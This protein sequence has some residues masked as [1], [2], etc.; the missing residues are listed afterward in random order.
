MKQT[1]QVTAEASRILSLAPAQR[2]QAIIDSPFT[3]EILE[4]LPTQDAYLIIKESF[5]SDSSILLQYSPPERIGDFIDLD[6]WEGDTL[7][8][9]NLCA[10]IAELAQA[11]TETLLD[12]LENLDPSLVILLFQPHLQVVITQPTDDNIPELI[13]NGYE[14]FDN[15]YFFTFDELSEQTQIL[16]TLLDTLFLHN[17]DLYYRVLEGVRWEL[18]SEM[19]E[20]AYQ[21]RA[22]RLMELGFPPP[23]EAKSIYRH[24]LPARIIARGLRSDQIPRMEDNDY[25]LPSLYREAITQG[26]LVAATD[27]DD[28]TRER[29]GFELV[30]LANKVVMA[31]YQPLND[32]Q[33]I[34]CA[35]AKAAAMTSLGLAIAMR[36]SLQSAQAVLDR[37]NA[38][39][40]FS[41]AFN[42]LSL[43]RNRLK[44]ILEGV[45][46]HMIPPSQREQSEDLLRTFPLYA[47]RVFSSLA[48]LDQATN[49]VERLAAL[50][51]IIHHIPWKGHVLDNTNIGLEGLDMENIILTALAVNIATR[52][53]TFRPLT[54]AELI[55]FLAQTTTYS[56]QHRHCKPGFKEDLSALLLG[57]DNS[58]AEHRIHDMAVGLIQRL[59]DEISALKDLNG[60]DP[61]FL[62]CLVVRR[63]NAA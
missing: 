11:S 62:T 9:D 46:P 37:L 17:Q 48:E 47:G 35:T 22:L 24:D 27:L 54:P 38:E 15:N 60:I 3:A 23:D 18:P 26:A 8:P 25:L 58:L 29:F 31:D 20:T 36:E 39:A 5:G 19:E 40:L 51:A 7:V 12:A 55:A 1:G 45:A 52:E 16:R 53:L 61:R 4:R 13:E 57:L 6:C 21:Q 32:A 10:W 33:A 50:R 44:G 43:V 2:A 34:R 30:Y 63:E 59:E 42:T 49:L 41:L 28:A 14:T 56:Q